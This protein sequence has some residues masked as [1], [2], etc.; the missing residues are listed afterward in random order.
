MEEGGRIAERDEKAGGLGAGP[1][2]GQ[3]RVGNMRRRCRTRSNRSYSYFLQ[4]LK[5]IFD[6][7]LTTRIRAC[8]TVKMTTQDDA[9]GSP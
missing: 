6:P 8:C 2:R 3:V 4:M 5:P 1:R 9:G 7:S